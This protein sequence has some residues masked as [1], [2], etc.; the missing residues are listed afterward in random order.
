MRVRIMSAYEAV[1]KIESD[2]TLAVD[3]FFGSCFP[4]E[5]AL[6]LENRFLETGEPR[7]LTLMYC[8]GQGD[9]NGRGLNHLGHKGLLKR[10]IGGHWGPL[11]R[12]Q[13]LAAENEIEGYNL[14]QG[15]IS[16][17][18]RDIA[19]GK[20]GVLTHVGLNTF[21]DPR[22]EGGKVNSS[23]REDIVELISIHDQEYLFYKTRPVHF[24]LLRGTS[25]DE[26]GNVTMEKESL[27]VEMLS[28]AAACKNSGGKVIV[29]VE[30][31]VKAGTLNPKLVKIPGIYVDTIVIASKPEYHM[32]TFSEQYNPS[33]SGEIRIPLETVKPMEMDER[34]IICRRAAMEL[35]EYAVINLGIGMPEGVASVANEE[36]IVDKVIPTV[37]PGPIGGVPAS[38]VSFGCAA[39]PEAVIDQPNQFDFY[40]G[41][42]L[43]M[44]FLGLAQVDRNGNV[45]VS[46][47]GKRIP[48][49]GGFIDITQNAKKVAYCGTFTADG[50]KI[51]VCE[52][53]LKIIKEGKVK[54]FIK[55]VEQITFSGKYALK[56]G[57]PVLYITERAVFELTKE[58]VMLKEIAPGIRIK[59]DIL[60]QMDFEPCMPDTIQKMD[61]RIFMKQKMGLKV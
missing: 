19:A 16:H 39:N 45:N 28:V 42:G 20:P 1:M 14:P 44:A 10:V 61:I 6:E 56:T 40:Q 22:I 13:K 15:V 31:L 37:E 52:G 41:G 49:C 11:P 5:L 35:K 47:F 38:G 12:I 46:K 50:L 29:Q 48:G 27:S 33:Y 57:Q 7:N 21:V 59:E 60:D 36:G 3:G 24:A 4:E 58:G 51:E 55:D 32:Q 2:S 17:M 8:A 25:A 30:R 43:D 34:K 23:A 9:G 18:F 53:G 26:N 54:K